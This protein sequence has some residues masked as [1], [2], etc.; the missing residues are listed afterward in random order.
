MRSWT[1]L[2]I[3]AAFIIL[4]LALSAVSKKTTTRNPA[5]RTAQQYL[6]ALT[7]N[8]AKTITRL[9]AKNDVV[10][11]AF[12]D[13]VVSIT[14]KECF[15][16]SGAFARQPEITWSRMDLENQQIDTN[17]KP[18]IQAE[19][20]LATVTLVGG[21]KIFMRQEKGSEQWKVFYLTQVKEKNR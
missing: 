17:L 21:R 11:K 8:D 4:V 16:Y 12:G 13:N 15:P 6:D 5:V 1:I 9:S 20:G 19:Q 7:A 2:I 14:F 10:I 3:F 18:Q